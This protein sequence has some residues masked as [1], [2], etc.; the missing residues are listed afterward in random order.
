MVE[1]LVDAGSFDFTT[2]TRQEL[3]E[4]V[5]PMFEQTSREQKEAAKGVMDFFSLIEGDEKNP[6]LIPPK[7]EKQQEKK[8]ILAKEKEFLGFYLTGHPMEEY[9]FLIDD[10]GCQPFHELESVDDGAVVKMAFIVES[11]KVK[12]SQKSQ[13]KFAILVISDGVERFE[14][15]IWPNMYEERHVLFI[16]SQLIFSILQVEKEGDSTKLRCRFIEDLTAITQENKGQL[17]ALFQ[18]A[19]SDGRRKKK[20]IVEKPM[21]S[22]ENKKLQLTLN[23]NSVRL[24]EIVKLKK[25]FHQYPGSSPITIAFHSAEQ[26]VGMV[27]IES[28]WGV[29][30]NT[31]LEN[32]IKSF[33]FIQTF[34]FEG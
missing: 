28:K 20:Q 22:C 6:F 17:D 18:Q 21:D 23:V 10:L 24:S 33:S 26:K 30:W 5:G 4:S 19:K 3:L 16:E 1:N 32:R 27:E 29:G 9:R 8:E 13:K 11:V 25:L 15:P 12:V 7:V 14:L 31:E 34:S 2:W